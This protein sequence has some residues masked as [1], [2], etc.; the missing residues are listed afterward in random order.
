MEKYPNNKEKEFLG[1]IDLEA[2]RKLNDEIAELT[3]EGYDVQVGERTDLAYKN[4][5]GIKK[6]FSYFR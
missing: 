4:P 2:S 1:G 3:K 6:V 5:Q